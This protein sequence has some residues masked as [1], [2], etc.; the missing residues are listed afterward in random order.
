MNM[1]KIHVALLLILLNNSISAQTW[2]KINSVFPLSDTLLQNTTVNFSNKDLGWIITSGSSKSGVQ[3]IKLLKTKNQGLEWQL[4]SDVTDFSSFSHTTSSFNENNIWF[5]G[6]TGDLV[7]SSDKG[8]KWDTSRITYDDLST[9]GWFFTSLYFFNEKNGIALN[10]FRW[11]TTDGGYSWNKVGDTISFFPNPTDLFFINDSIGWMVSNIS[12]VFDVGSI[13]KTTDGG[14]NWHYQDKRAP[15]LYGVYFIN[16]LKGFA[17]GN[18]NSICKTIDGGISWERNPLPGGT[19]WCIEFLDSLN[20]WIGG[21]GKILRTTD[22][23]DTW[24]TEIDSIGS[25][26]KQMIMLKENKVVYAMGKDWNG[27]SHTLL[28]SDLSN[29]SSVANEED[30]LPEQ[31]LLFDNYPNPFNP[32]TTISYYIPTTTYVILKIYNILGKEIA[33]LVKKEQSSGKYKVKFEANDLPTGI[34]FYQIKTNKYVQ[35]KKMLLLR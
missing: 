6:Q 35:S 20:G 30:N 12:D 34:Y 11:S 31:F 19:F 27:Y 3:S 24:E 8:E 26:F 21:K 25:D 16:T 17:V 4:E 32:S 1:I 23:G 14:K 15:L 5:M 33:T 18:T 2:E 29:I 22:G 28:R 13:A 7:F 10:N 9:S